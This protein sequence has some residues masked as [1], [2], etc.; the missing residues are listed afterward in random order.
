MD[1]EALKTILTVIIMSIP[2]VII[3]IA[4]ASRYLW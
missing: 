1:E 4:V 2:V 3:G